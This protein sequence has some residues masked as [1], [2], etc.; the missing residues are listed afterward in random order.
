MLLLTATEV[1]IYA[2]R[3]LET[4]NLAFLV[5]MGYCNNDSSVR[6]QQVWRLRLRLRL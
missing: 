6:I 2:F 1:Q 4:A 3:R 5:P